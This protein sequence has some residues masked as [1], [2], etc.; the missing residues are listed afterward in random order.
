MKKGEALFLFSL[1]AIPPILDTIRKKR[2]REGTKHIAEGKQAKLFF[3]FR[4]EK[5]DPKIENFQAS[6][7][8]SWIT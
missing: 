7:L 8:R 2:S 6:V 5:R 1:F 4:L 3:F